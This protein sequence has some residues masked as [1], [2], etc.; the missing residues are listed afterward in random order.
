[1]LVIVAPAGTPATVTFL[2][3]SPPP[4]RNPPLVLFVKH[5]VVGTLP[6]LV[7]SN[8][9]GVP[10]QTAAGVADAVTVGEGL[11]LTEVV[12]EPTHPLT[13][14]TV[15]VM[16]VL[17]LVMPVTNPA[18]SIVATPGLLLVQTPPPVASVNVIVLPAQTLDRPPMAAIVG[19]GLTV[20]EAVN[21]SRETS[22]GSTDNCKGCRL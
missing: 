16:T 11:T 21:R 7:A 20:T 19:G 8:D 15:Y 4:R 12:I 10:A 13:S 9:D 1:M 18:A 2:T 3:R 22:I 5:S 6:G 14:V 17:P